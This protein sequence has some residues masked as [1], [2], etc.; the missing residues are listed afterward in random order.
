MIPPSSDSAE[1]SSQHSLRQAILRKELKDW[2]RNF[3][4]THAGRKAT[5]DEIK[6][7]RDIAAKYKEYNFLRDVIAG[8]VSGNPS[9]PEDVLQ[10]DRSTTPSRKRK[11][12]ESE[13]RKER[14]QKRDDTLLAIK[15]ENGIDQDA[16][17]RKEENEDETEQQTPR[18]Q[19]VHPT[20]QRDGRVLGL[21]DTLGE[22]PSSTRSVRRTPGQ[23]NLKGDTSIGDTPSRHVRERMRAPLSEQAVNATPTRSRT[24]S[25]TL[26]QESVIHRT[27]PQIQS[28]DTTYNTALDATP[29]N[30]RKSFRTPPSTGR[31]FLLNHVLTTSTPSL[32]M[33]GRKRKLKTMQ[34]PT[35]I[36][37]TPTSK[38]VV[39]GIDNNC[40]FTTPSFLR[41]RPVTHT[42]HLPTRLDTITEEP[43]DD[44]QGTPSK[45]A[46]TRT[47]HRSNTAPAPLGVTSF[48]RRPGQH[49]TLGRTLSQMLKDIK[50]NED[51]RL[52]EEQ[53]AFDEVE[54]EGG[55][56][57]RGDDA[58]EVEGGEE[59]GS[60]PRW[61][62][63]GAK[64][65]T[66]KAVLK[67][68]PPVKPAPEAAEA[69]PAPAQIQET[70]LA[71]QDD[72]NADDE[73]DRRDGARRLPDVPHDDDNLEPSKRQQAPPNHGRASPKRRKLN[74]LAHTNFTKLKIRGKGA[75][76]KPW[77]RR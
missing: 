36:T 32:F 54:G 56:Q 4:T 11:R 31:R 19:F 67:P 58:E 62:K 44:T 3:T 12:K 29:T 76:P 53:A 43:E 17:A 41:T 8:K 35:D 6:A 28:Q 9:N 73:P 50:K 18:K 75:K 59:E 42:S 34:D 61:K 72:A 30:P 20:P 40:D 69:D 45:R 22:T 15:S 24:S 25:Y 46:R 27:P 21:F 65:Q 57:A 37:S 5:R 16:D 39:T 55:S 23:R 64:R 70:Q 52:D 66:R 63:K 33:S 48:R 7:D 68:K 60:K 14:A 49:G 51:D 1:I 2:E 38:S 10:N 26:H 13:G 71:G 47:L 74:P 77:R